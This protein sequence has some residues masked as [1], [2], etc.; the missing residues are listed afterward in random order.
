M[1]MPK[2][3]VRVLQAGKDVDEK[4]MAVVVVRFSSVPVFKPRLKVKADR[5]KTVSE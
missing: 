1:E 2:R 3:A 5:T 4:L